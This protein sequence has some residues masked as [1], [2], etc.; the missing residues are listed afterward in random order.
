MTSKLGLSSSLWRS[1]Q[2]GAN[3]H[4]RLLHFWLVHLRWLQNSIYL[5]H[6]SDFCFYWAIDAGIPSRR[7]NRKSSFLGKENINE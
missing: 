4:Q 6:T 5:F 1:P 7:E 2:T 3:I